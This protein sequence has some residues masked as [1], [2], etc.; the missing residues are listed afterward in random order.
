MKIVVRGTNWVGDAVMTI[1]AL[2]ELRRVFPDSEITLHTHSWAQGV[3][4]NANF[5]NE[6]L[7]FEPGKSNFKIVLA[8]AK[9]WRERKFDLAVVLP[10]SFPPDFCLCQNNFEVGFSRLERQN[11][12]NK[13]CILKNALRPGMR[14]QSY[15]RIGEN[16]AQF[17]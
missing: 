14:V 4:Q 9:I 5:I 11:F 13:I 17:S 12:I 15:F 7:P 16:A 1:P 8:Q 10:N 2:R 6:I 3:F